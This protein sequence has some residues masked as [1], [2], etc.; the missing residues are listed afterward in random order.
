MYLP[1]KYVPL[2]LDNKGYSPQQAWQILSQ[3]F[4]DDN[5]LQEPILTWLHASLHATQANNR[6]PPTTSLG[7]TAPFL[8]ED[9]INHREPVLSTVLPGLGQPPAGLEAAIAQMAN[10]VVNQT[11][12]ARNARM[13]RELECEQPTTPSTKFGLLL[14]S[15]KSYLHVTAK[16]QLP[17]FWFQLAAAPKKQ[18]FSII[19]EYFDAFAHSDQAFL[20][21]APIPTPKLL[22]DLTTVTFLV[23]N[24]DDLKTG[25]QP[26]AAMDGSEDHWAA[27][28]ELAW[29]FN[30]VYE[31][32]FSIAFHN[33][34]R[35]KVPKDLHS[36]PVTFFDLECNLGIFGNL[37]SSIL[38]PHHPLTA[39][40]RLFWDAL[41]RQ[42]RQQVQHEI[43]V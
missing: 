15:L 21:V 41:S 10:A 11:S 19:R 22:A 24:P 31:H 25:I 33:L 28:L 13:V 36:Y 39:N 35:F 14:D 16:E 4:Q 37:M 26:F 17:E 42:C 1:L 43:D 8:D 29:S 12:E 5:F 23:D 3:A 34:D 2:L 20:P 32:D 9:L 7:I 30:L 18:E 27:T 6:G 40:Y 38:G